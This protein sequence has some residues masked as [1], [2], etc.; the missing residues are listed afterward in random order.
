MAFLLEA[1]LDGDGALSMEELTARLDGPQPGGGQ[2]QGPPQ[3]KWSRPL[4]AGGVAAVAAMAAALTRTS[5]ARRHRGRLPTSAPARSG[6][7]PA[8]PGPAWSTLLHR[9][10][11]VTNN[12]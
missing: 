8:A 5:P 3:A 2:R 10:R 7:G 11:C 12:K 1:D 4:M 9:N 6:G